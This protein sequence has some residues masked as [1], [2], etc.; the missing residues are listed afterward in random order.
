MRGYLDKLDASEVHSFKIF[1]GA[2]AKKSNFI[3]TLNIKK[4]INEE[5]FEEFFAYAMPRFNNYKH[6]G[7]QW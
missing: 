7:S 3:M 5:A 1:L 6:K 2:F 4:K